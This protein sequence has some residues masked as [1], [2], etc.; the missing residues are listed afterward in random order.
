MASD[1]QA[2]V[3]TASYTTTLGT[4]VNTDN[5]AAIISSNTSA[6]DPTT[7]AYVDGLT[8]T[9]LAAELSNVTVAVGVDKASVM[10]TVSNYGVTLPSGTDAITVGNTI[11]VFDTMP[12]NSN[13]R[14]TEQDDAALLGHESIHA[15]QASARGSTEAFLSDYISGGSYSTN[16]LEQSAY[17]FGPKN[18]EAGNAGSTPILYQPENEG[19]YK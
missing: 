4:L 10:S 19:W 5:L 17:N 16:P 9:Q 2:A 18:T 6:L 1:L 7:A 11:M 8:T 13:G 12:T 14:V 3:N 15:L